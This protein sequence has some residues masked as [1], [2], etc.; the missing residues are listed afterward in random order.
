MDPGS[1]GC[2]G[3]TLVEM[4]AV[5]PR[6]TPPVARD[7]EAQSTLQ[8]LLSANADAVCVDAHRPGAHRQRCLEGSEALCTSYRL[9]LDLHHRRG[10]ERGCH[11]RRWRRK[12]R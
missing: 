12:E 8:T 9:L 11:T 2:R 6:V 3:D 4:V 10:G 5:K 7:Q 1:S